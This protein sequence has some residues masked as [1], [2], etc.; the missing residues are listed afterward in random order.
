MVNCLF[1]WQ[2]M[3]LFQH[4]LM[5]YKSN[6]LKKAVLFYVNLWFFC[7]YCTVSF[8]YNDSNS[9][10]I[11]ENDNTERWF[12]EK[13]KYTSSSIMF[14]WWTWWIVTFIGCNIEIWNEFTCNKKYIYICTLL[15]FFSVTKCR[16]LLAHTEDKT[17]FVFFTFY[18]NFSCFSGILK[19]PS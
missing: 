2:N 13:F 12:S 3:S 9:P 17:H 16:W 11:K 1:Q 4:Y 14:W 18:Y 19:I 15:S 5:T 7:S 6:T 10:I 8:V